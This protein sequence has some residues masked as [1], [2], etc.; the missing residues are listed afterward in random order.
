MEA[1]WSDSDH[2]SFARRGIPAICFNTGLH[3]DYHQPTDTPDKI[4][5]NRLASVVR[6]V[7]DLAMLTAN[8]DAP[9]AVIPASVWQGWAWGPYD[10]P[11]LRRGLHRSGEKNQQG[12]CL[13]F[14]L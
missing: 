11:N 1:Y 3:A 2:Y 10:S 9:P 6:I 14:G 12:G 8:A 5:Y 13:G 4:N 7:R